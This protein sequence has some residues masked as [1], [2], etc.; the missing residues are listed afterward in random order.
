MILSDTAGDNS[1]NRKVSSKDVREIR[2]AFEAGECPQKLADKYGV[3]RA[4]IHNIAK[5]RSWKSVD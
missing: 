2:R 1:R 3:R 5:H 4:T